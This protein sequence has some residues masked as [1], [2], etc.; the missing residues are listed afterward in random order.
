MPVS[1]ATVHFVLLPVLE[2][3]EYQATNRVLLAASEE[4]EDSG[5]TR[6]KDVKKSQAKMLTPTLSKHCIAFLLQM[7]MANSLKFEKLNINCYC[8]KLQVCVL[9]IKYFVSMWVI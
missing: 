6:K 8:V 4:Y 1:E 9:T 7:I 5:T 2:Q 3:F